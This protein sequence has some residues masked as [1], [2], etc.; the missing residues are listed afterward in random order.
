MFVSWS[1]LL[2][3]K[4]LRANVNF[5]QVVGALAQGNQLGI[6]PQISLYRKTVYSRQLR[7]TISNTKTI[8]PII[9]FDWCLEKKF[10]GVQKL[11]VYLS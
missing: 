3:F 9:I 11:A 5:W 1:L 7:I 8:I 4:F 10:L 6:E 2:S